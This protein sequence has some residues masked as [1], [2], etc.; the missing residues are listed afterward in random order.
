M[1]NDDERQAIIDLYHRHLSPEEY[2]S[3]LHRINPDRYHGVPFQLN[4]ETL[5]VDSSC[6]NYGKHNRLVAM[7]GLDQF[8]NL[9]YIREDFCSGLAPATEEDRQRV[10]A[11]EYPTPRGWRLDFINHETW[12]HNDWKSKETIYRMTR[13]K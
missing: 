3:E 13:E 8:H 7:R 12:H 6:T 10:L 2:A 5:D 4:A 1:T 9:I 11:D